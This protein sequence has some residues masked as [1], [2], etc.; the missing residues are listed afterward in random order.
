MLGAALDTYAALTHVTDSVTSL[1]EIFFFIKFFFLLK[2]N[3]MENFYR[4]SESFPFF[5]KSNIHI[6]TPVGVCL[7]A[8]LCSLAALNFELLQRPSLVLETKD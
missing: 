8:D 1:N 2:K 7:C 5:Q 4:C 3:P 6:L